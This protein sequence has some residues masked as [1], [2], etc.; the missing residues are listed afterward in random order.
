MYATVTKNDVQQTITNKP[1]YYRPITTNRQFDQPITSSG[2]VFGTT[3]QTSEKSLQLNQ[4]IASLKNARIPSSV[5]GGLTRS[6]TVT[7]APISSESLKNIYAPISSRTKKDAEISNIYANYQQIDT[8]KNARIGDNRVQASRQVETQKVE[9]IEVKR[10]KQKQ[11]KDFFK[12]LQETISQAQTQQGQVAFVERTMKSH[13]D[14][15]HNLEN[16]V[17]NLTNELKNIPETERVKRLYTRMRLN[18]VTKILTDVKLAVVASQEKLKQEVAK[19]D[20]LTEE[21]KAKLQQIQGLRNEIAILRKNYANNVKNMQGK[22][23]DVVEAGR[24]ANSII[25]QD[26]QERIAAIDELRTNLGVT[27][28]EIKAKES[29]FI[30]NTL[31]EQDRIIRQTHVNAARVSREQ[32]IQSLE[33]EYQN[34]SRQRTVDAPVLANTFKKTLDIMKVSLILLKF[35]K[36]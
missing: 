19:M 28:S 20:F 16:D 18:E 35:L 23:E 3:T 26:I 32:S 31:I 13:Q 8:L 5:T 29:A 34:T 12:A 1:G 2:E 11:I 27:E 22:A 7:A 10:E 9:P 24:Q 33:Q 6:Q 21:Q 14:L 4:Q 15:V 25:E 30:K 17:A 36:I